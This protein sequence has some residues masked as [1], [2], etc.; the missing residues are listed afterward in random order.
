MHRPF[1]VSVPSD[2][3]VLAGLG[4]RL[5][6]THHDLIGY[7]NPA[8]FP[9]RDAWLGYRELTATGLAL[10]DHVVFDSAHVRED[11]LA[12]GLLEPAR[13]S[14]VHLG[15]D[16]AV[17]PAPAARRPDGLTA[18]EPFLLCL[19]TDL[20]H[21]NRL[22]ALRLLYE[23]RVRG[24]WAG[25]LVLA[26]PSV[27]Q[28]SSRAHERRF[29]AE[30]PELSPAIADCGPV[31]EPEKRWL[32]EHA[33]LV[34]YPTVQE[35]FGLLPFEA[36]RH[37]TPC[38]WAAGSAL[39]ETLPESLARIVPW[40]AGASAAP[41]RELIEDEAARSAQ[42]EAIRSVAG[43]LRWEQTATALLALYRRTC[44]APPAPA[45]VRRTGP[46]AHAARDQRRRDAAGRAGRGPSRRRLMAPA[47]TR[48][49]PPACGCRIRGLTR[50]ATPGHAAEPAASRGRP[51]NCA[52]D[53][54]CRHRAG[55]QPQ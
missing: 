27:S 47:R 40:D 32:L 19:G 16:H 12:E 53:R 29:L 22:F 26:G 17:L 31:T 37:G 50:R 49:A 43:E 7:H 44:E 33:A 13:G 10:A 24:G 15:V 41:A 46:G 38:L 20:L 35:G 25:G 1:Q 9:D 36:A 51:R 23:L 45:G 28:G 14:V 34:V 3:T 30:H 39:S 2:L 18:V 8:Y 11:A 21:K 54:R 5:V 52:A 42:I 55:R 48:G 6:I 4:E